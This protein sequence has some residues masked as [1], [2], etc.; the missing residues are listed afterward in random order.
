LVVYVMPSSLPVVSD[1]R[2]LRN[3][4]E[5][6]FYGGIRGILRLP[7]EHPLDAMKT[8]WQ[9]QP[10]IR[11][12]RDVGV[13]IWRDRGVAGF[14][15]GAV[16][17]SVRVTLKEVYRWPLMMC[18]PQLFTTIWPSGPQDPALIK[19]LTGFSLASVESF[20]ICPLERLK[21]VLM[22]RPASV[23]TR[24]TLQ[25][26]ISGLTAPA[27]H[28]GLDYLFQG[29]GAVYARQLISWVSFL[30]ADAK[31]KGWARRA[32]HKDYL[33]FGTLMAVAT[34]VGLINTIAVMPADCIKTK[35][36]Q[37]APSTRA[38]APS[39]PL[40]SA[41]PRSLG[42]VA[43]ARHIYATQGYQGF[44]VGWR[45]RFLQY[46]LNAAFSSALLEWLE[47]RWILT[48]RLVPRRKEEAESGEGE[49]VT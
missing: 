28:H 19:T 26:I 27:S 33:D 15:A 38:Q 10:Q 7:F 4:A 16:P 24:Q 31:L 46:M 8:Y 40:P 9:A 18:L 13:A 6:A 45:V 42:F 11:S 37:F 22:T 32:T 41:A 3:Y 23:T 47:R 5:V 14:Y 20:I 2:F 43:T 30:A 39:P 44:Y 35:Q 49:G 17:N 29:L 25:H 21:V 1:E 36:Q 34:G 12:F 48:H